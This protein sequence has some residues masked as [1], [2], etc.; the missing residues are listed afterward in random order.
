MTDVLTLVEGGIAV[1]LAISPII[2]AKYKD[3]AYAISVVQ[4]FL[5]IVRVYGSAILDGSIT[6]DEKIK[7][8]DAFIAVASVTHFDKLVNATIPTIDDETVRK[9]VKT[10]ESASELGK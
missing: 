9:A 6:D 1:L 5:D 3:A 2:V 4:S 10:I 8:A 7:I